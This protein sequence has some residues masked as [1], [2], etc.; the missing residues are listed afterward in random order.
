MLPAHSFIWGYDDPLIEASKTFFKKLPFDKFGMLAT[1]SRIS[2]CYFY[3][4]EAIRARDFLGFILFAIFFNLKYFQRNGTS[5]DVLTIH[6]GEGDIR[7]LAVIDNFN[8]SPKLNFWGTDECNRVDGSDGSQFPPHFLDKKHELQI[9]IKSFCRKLPLVYD[10][11]VNIFDGIPAW[12]Y[13][14]PLDVFDSPKTNPANQ[15]YCHMESGTCPPKGVFN[16]TKCFDAP[17]FA[18]FP[19][20]FMGE[21]SLFRNIE[22]LNPDE[23]KHRTYADV[24]PRLAFPI[25]GASRFQINVQAQPVDMISGKT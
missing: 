22:G 15:C 12:R 11:E 14:A 2:C 25:D 20:F 10:S 7:K 3:G 19:H 16:V 9:F 5:S 1:V 21:E 13:K 8:G 6:S 4:S 23:S 17:I 18:S 24:H